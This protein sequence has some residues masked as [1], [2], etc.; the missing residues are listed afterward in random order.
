MLLSKELLDHT[1]IPTFVFSLCSPTW[2]GI[3]VYSFC[4]LLLGKLTNSKLRQLFESGHCSLMILIGWK[5][6]SLL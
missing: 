1:F 4:N 3:L 2:F 6:K 5:E